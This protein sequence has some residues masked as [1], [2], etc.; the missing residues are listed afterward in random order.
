MCAFA[1]IPVIMLL[2][3]EYSFNIKNDASELFVQKPT[4]F[5][6]AEYFFK[7]FLLYK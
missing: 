5:L 2:Y 7:S 1:S 3:K 4:T 6:N